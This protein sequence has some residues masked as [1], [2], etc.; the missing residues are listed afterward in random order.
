MHMP[1]LSPARRSEAVRRFGERVCW[2]VLAVCFLVLLGWVFD[3]P[4]LKSGIPLGPTMKIT[5][6]LGVVLTALS[7]LAALAERRRALLSWRRHL[8]S[9]SLGA[10]A[11]VVVFGVVMVAYCWVGDGGESLPKG[12]PPSWFHKL[13]RRPSL[14]SSLA[15]MLA[16]LSLLTWRHLKSRVLFF[17]L[18]GSVVLIAWLGLA[19]LILG[20]R[21][22]KRSLFFE[23]LS[24]P[25]ALAVMALGSV[26]FCLRPMQGVARLFSSQNHAGRLVRWLAPAG[27]LL[28]PLLGGLVLWAQARFQFT[29]AFGIAV[30]GSTL[31][32][33]LAFVSLR[34]TWIL[35]RFEQSQHRAETKTAQAIKQIAASE[36]L[37]RQFIKHTPAAIAML[38]TRMR[39]VQASDRWLKDYH[40]DGQ[41][42]I[43]R[44]HYDI[45]PDIPQ[46][47]K[48]I[49]QRVLAGAVE[50]CDEDPFPRSTGGTEWLQWEA[51]PWHNAAGEV[52]GLVF[53][54]QVITARKEAE[55]QMRESEERFRGAFENAPIGMA[56]VSLEG[57]WMRVNHAI[58]RLVGRSEEELLASTFQDI[59]H[60]D[61]LNADLDQVRALIGGQRDHYTMEK[62]YFHKSGRIVW[63]LL[64]VTIIRR[65][66][67]EPL[68]FV[69]QI[70]DITASHEAAESMRASLEEKEVLLR[71]IHH[72]VKNNLQVISSLLQLQSGYLNDPQDVAMFR[73]CQARIHAMGLVHDRLYRSDNLSTIDFSEHLREL[74]SLI[75]RGQSSGMENIRMVIQSDAIE[76]NLD[77]AIPLGLITAELI[78]NAYKHAFAGRQ[79]GVI[80]V[81][82]IRLTSQD[83]ELTVEDDGVGLPAAFDPAK[84]RSLGLRLIR[85]LAGQLRADFSISSP[86]AGSRARLVVP[87]ENPLTPQN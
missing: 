82:L 43:G 58:C 74:V 2:G 61:D 86:G 39:Y 17:L 19:G 21:E 59:T 10:A 84:A 38:D 27:A 31:F 67:G 22:G 13:S 12:Q 28:T 35:L 72:R 63:A 48:D 26:L 29:P 45:F 9:F 3:V 32:L 18:N 23:L 46:R 55:S 85:A 78:T 42:I 20:V 77:T 83:L 52:G 54:T 66:D 60:P 11:V 71:E 40:L 75:V 1:V 68:H 15:L 64:A 14:S 65:E 7:L 73:E 47:W 5:T 25:T 24:F 56:M 62:R 57:R 53:Y 80:T 81:S 37:L 50:S 44:S 51:R 87:A 49:H 36:E 79:G 69:S 16:G 8:R 30:Y 41:A 33:A 34:G 6:A 4:L 76:V 70:E